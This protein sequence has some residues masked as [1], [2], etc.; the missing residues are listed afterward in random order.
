MAKV[1]KKSPPRAS[2]LKKRRRAKKS[3]RRRPL[4]PAPVE[5]APP[6]TGPKARIQLSLLGGSAEVTGPLSD[7]CYTPESLLGPLRRLLGGIDTDPCWSPSSLVRPRIAGYTIADDCLSK[8]WFGSVLLN[9][10]YSKPEPFVR[11]AVE[12][13][14]LGHKVAIIVNVDPST[15]WWAAMHNGP[16]KPSAVLLWP[17]RVRFLGPFAQGRP[18]RSATAVILYNVPIEEVRKELPTIPA[19]SFA[20]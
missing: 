10:P 6:E 8:E 4:E 11:R 9:P 5:E 18:A 2:E 14:A 19:Y 17:D 16:I 12:H 13:A 1:A 3:V 15:E 7:E 20:A